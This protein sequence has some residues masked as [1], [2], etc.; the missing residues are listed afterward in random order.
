MKIIVYIGSFETKTMKRIIRIFYFFLATTP[1]LIQGQTN[2]ELSSSSI[3]MVN[4][5]AN[6]FFA[7]SASNDVY[8]LTINGTSIINNGIV[9]T[10][11]DNLNS[12]AI[13]N[14]L[15]NG[16]S[17]QLFY[18][19][20][21]DSLK[22]YDG[23]NWNFLFYDP[24][25]F[26][27]AGGSGPYVY[28][29]S[30]AFPSTIKRFTGSALNTILVDSSLTFMVAD[31]GVTN[32]GTI[33]YFAGTGATSLFMYEISSTGNLLNTYPINLYSAGAYGCFVM[34]NTIYVGIGPAGLPANS[35]IPI[36]IS[37][38]IAT[39][40]SP[41]PMPALNFKDLASCTGE[42]TG[43]N[44]LSS[45]TLA[46]FPNP[47]SDFINIETGM[48]DSEGG[49]LKIY[50]INSR[51][52][53]DEYLKYENL[54]FSQRNVTDLECGIYFLTIQTKNSTYTGKFIIE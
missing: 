26:H 39:V 34:N 4:C 11:V 46:I 5:S 28:F 6:T 14:D 51:I 23:S 8:S 20:N 10:S 35:L 52:I 54:N 47:S 24:I 3:D 19:T 50:D 44:T 21:V 36:T 32:F 2:E 7:L 13:G 37:G 29:M 22:Y 49:H 31:L 25:T 16:T 43:I 30:N 45:A 40:G 42:V 17:Q 12:L 53:K 38:L 27:N 15:M 48:I 33:Y 9:A 1:L 18:S 41:I